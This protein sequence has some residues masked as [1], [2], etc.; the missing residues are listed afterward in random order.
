MSRSQAANPFS[1]RVVLGMLLFGALA[2]LLTLYFIGAG[3]TGNGSNSS[4]HGASRGLNGY[5]ALVSLLEKGGYETSL[6][7]NEG[8]LAS[9]GLLILTPPHNADGKD[10]EKIVSRRRYAGPTLVVTP[11][12]YAAPLPRT[13]KGAKKGWVGL[14]GSGSPEWKGFADDVSVSIG[15][16]KG[17]RGAALSG[18]LPDETQ[19]QSGSR[20][21]HL[22]SLVRTGDGKRVLAGYIADGG[23]YP[24][25]NR[26]AGIDPDFGGDD[27]NLYPLVFVFEPDLLDNYGM[28]SEANAQLAAKLIEATAEDSDG[29]VMF[30]LTQNGLG[31]A[32]NLLTLAFKPPFLAATLCLV[33]AATVI[34]WRAFRR[35]GPPLAEAAAIPFGKRQ[36]VENAAGL[37]RRTRRLHL[38]GPPYAALMRRRI[39][40]ALGLQWGQ[41]TAAMDG[42]IDHALATRG[43]TGTPFFALTEKLAH[44]RSEHELLRA[45]NALKQIERMLGK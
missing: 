13:A 37:I 27:E 23:Y 31:R 1:P 32:M 38:L 41:N 42:S 16:A 3:E 28:A 10:L 30:D 11:K 8:S 35:F 34:G 14:F 44:A 33:I 18:K 29:K 5:A 4:G 12:W 24:A 26:L 6:L 7:R 25:L 19:V 43:A 36:L 20:N 45:A 15:K 9:R 39:A 22:I 40:D 21:S 2:F 17:W